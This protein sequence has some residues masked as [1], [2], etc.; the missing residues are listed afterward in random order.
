MRDA[1]DLLSPLKEPRCSSCRKVTPRAL[2]FAGQGSRVTPRRTPLAPQK[3]ASVG[4]VNVAGIKIAGRYI[5][6]GNGT[7]LGMT[8]A[9]AGW[10][11]A[12][13]CVRP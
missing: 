8:N 6:C 10:G 1:A 7:W 13:A 2:P 12:A 4:A 11:E 3:C 5:A 9:P